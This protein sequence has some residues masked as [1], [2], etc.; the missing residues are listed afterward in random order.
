MLEARR[1]PKELQKEVAPIQK[2]YWEGKPQNTIEIIEA[3][4]EMNMDLKGEILKRQ[5]EDPFIVKEIRRIDEGRNSLFEPQEENSLWFQNRICVPDIPKIKKVILREAHQTAYSIH[6]G[7]TKMY[8]DLKDVFWWNNMK[9]EVAKCV[10]KCHTC[11]RVK[12]KHQSHAG[13]LQPLPIPKWKWEEIGM[14]FVTRLPMTKNQKDMIWVIVDKLTKSAHFLAVNQKNS[15]EKLA[16]IYVNE[17]VSKHGI[18]KK[19]VS[20]RGLIRL[21]RIY[22]F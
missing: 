15:C 17:I 8:I 11:Q 22:N 14:D 12:A 18:P 9:R 21:K 10:F 16:E 3:L 19:I 13:K 20:D 1:M 5:K 4:T 7:S 6:P 2:E